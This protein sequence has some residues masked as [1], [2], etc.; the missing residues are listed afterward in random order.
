VS[1]R[2][3][4]L[5]LRH[6]LV[7]S[8]LT[9][10]CSFAAA[11]EKR[12]TGQKTQYQIFRTYRTAQ[13]AEARPGPDPA[14]CTIA[15]AFAS[16]S[17]AKYI[18]ESFS[19]SNVK[20]SDNG[21]PDPHNITDL[22]I[23]EAQSICGKHY[24]MSVVV[25]VGPGIP[26]QGDVWKLGGLAKVFSFGTPDSG[27]GMPLFETTAHRRTEPERDQEFRNLQTGVHP[28]KLLSPDTRAM[29]PKN[30]K[31]LKPMSQALIRELEIE[32]AIKARLAKE[33]PPATDL[34]G[35]ERFL[36]FRLGP[37]EAPKTTAVNDV[38]AAD[39]VY[40]A[41]EEY[42]KKVRP[43]LDDVIASRCRSELSGPVV[44]AA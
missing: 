27:R 13:D 7:L 14:G 26:T 22:A 5:S 43:Q 2:V 34:V 31:P 23:D 33:Y 40:K 6:R 3:S 10:K 28:S 4:S 25:N 38:F 44:A 29:S 16:T 17:A 18:F 8:E 20:F 15:D 37:S 36:Y 30:R 41:T 19:V 24:P 42:L 1:A 39:I 12:R 21:F 11:A 32:S 9:Q 35:N